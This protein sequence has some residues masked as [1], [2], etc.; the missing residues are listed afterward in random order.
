MIT[1]DQPLG[2][3]TGANAGS[4]TAARISGASL[5]TRLLNPLTLA[6]IATVAAGAAW[7]GFPT[8]QHEVRFAIGILG[9]GDGNAIGNYFR[10]LGMWGPVISLSLMLLQAILA[11]IPGSLIGLANGLA[12]GIF[13]GGLLTL[14]G[15]T[16]AAIV[17]FMLARSLGR[18]RIESMIG[19]T[20]GAGSGWLARWGA[21]GIVATR[22]APGLSFDLISY[23]AGLTRMPAARFLVATVVGSA[24]QAFFAAWLVQRSPLLGWAFAGIG[25]VVMAGLAIFALARRRSARHP[26]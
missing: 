14:S 1:V 22:L 11:P 12:Y 18:A 4:L 13:W 7:F 20:E 2:R 6:A 16:L 24:P 10:S 3:I 8:V 21:A 23:A 25:L 19:A 5:L 15:Q 17:C 9:D 26:S